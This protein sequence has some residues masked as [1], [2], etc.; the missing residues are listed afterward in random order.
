MNNKNIFAFLFISIF[1]LSGCEVNNNKEVTTT[2]QEKQNTLN[3]TIT[4]TINTETNL[5]N[6]LE[7]T[8]E[9]I[10]NIENTPDADFLNREK[11]AEKIIR[12]LETVKNWLKQFSNPDGTSPIT[13]GKAMIIPERNEYDIITFHLYESTKERNITFDWYDVDMNTKTVTNMILEEVK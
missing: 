6:T 10:S 11:Q 7:N 9:N 3:E 5:D 12:N 13:G 1:L 4:S 8:S 2:N